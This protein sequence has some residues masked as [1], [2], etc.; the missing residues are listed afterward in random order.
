MTPAPPGFGY[1][2]HEYAASLPHIG[3]PRALV[4][5]GGW[6]LERPVPRAGLDQASGVTDLCAPYP[7]LSVPS[8]ERLAEAL[9][10]WSDLTGGPVTAT[11]VVDP[12]LQ[13]DPAALA[14]AFPDHLMVFKEHFVADLE[15]PAL[16]I[17]SPHHRR[18]ARRGLRRVE[19]ERVPAPAATSAVWDA[20]KDLYAVLRR[21]HSIQGAAAFPGASF[22]ALTAT[23]GL[24][25]YVA[26]KGRE[27]CGMQLWIR[28]GPHAWYHLAAT[29]EVGYAE[30]A[31]YA[32]MASALD[33]LRTNGVET[34]LL[35]AGAGSTSGTVQDGLTRFKGG[36]ATRTLPAHLGG[37]VLNRGA[38]EALAASRGPVAHDD[39]FPRYRHP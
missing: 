15:R 5:S 7:L 8:P 34:A 33:E 3:E 32:L 24:E 11:A 31:A 1:A 17:A 18:D 23:P 37:R 14:A 13:A 36:F 30:G 19:V 28:D 6:M 16:E 20:W 10:A 25:A 21:R 4:E 39:W 27:V 2:S 22:D 38:Y 35:G 29:N 12:L 9:G 26:R